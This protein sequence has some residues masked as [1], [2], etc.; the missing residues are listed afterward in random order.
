[1]KNAEQLKRSIS[2]DL[3]DLCYRIIFKEYWDYRNELLNRP[4][5]R[6]NED[7]LI[8][9]AEREFKAI[10]KKIGDFIDFLFYEI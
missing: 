9:E 1:M 4:I 2:K 6:G 10:D 8:E 7:E 5:L 3:N